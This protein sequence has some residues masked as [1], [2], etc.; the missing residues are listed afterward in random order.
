MAVI[1]CSCYCTNQICG[2]LWLGQWILGVLI[3]MDWTKECVGH[4]RSK[5]YIYI[6]IFYVHVAMH[7]G[8]IVKTP[9]AAT[10]IASSVVVMW[11][12]NWQMSLLAQNVAFSVHPDKK[13]KKKM[14][15]ASKHFASSFCALVNLSWCRTPVC[16]LKQGH[17]NEASD[18]FHTTVAAVHWNWNVVIFGGNAGICRATPMNFSLSTAPNSHFNS[19]L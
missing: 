6:Y 1:E 13:K 15:Q 19:L 10:A 16:T 5:Q 9:S 3:C 7:Y 2:S 11:W 12:L 4:Y 18:A 8:L 17:E 14:P